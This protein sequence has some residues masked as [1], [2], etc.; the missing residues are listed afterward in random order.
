MKVLDNLKWNA[1]SGCFEEEGVNVSSEMLKNIREEKRGELIQAA[2]AA[3]CEA[4]W[5]ASE[6]RE[7]GSDVGTQGH[8][9]PEGTWWS[10]FVDRLSSSW[11]SL[12]GHHEALVCEET[13]AEWHGTPAGL[14]TL[15]A[16]QVIEK[17]AKGPKLRGELML[18]FLFLPFLV[19]FPNL[20]LVSCRYS[21][22]HPAG[23]EHNMWCQRTLLSLQMSHWC[24]E[25]KGEMDPVR[26][27]TLIVFHEKG[28]G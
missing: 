18:V 14:G 27:E 21:C 4:S 22:W 19:E 28:M 5:E 10:R 3:D 6:H 11:E 26:V 25:P 20:N 2:Y 13:L 1:P 12:Q 24:P 15:W 7:G 9:C 16:D 23:E 8:T 17:V